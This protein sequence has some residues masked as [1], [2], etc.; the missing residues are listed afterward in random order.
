MDRCFGKP[1]FDPV[2]QWPRRHDAFFPV[3]RPQYPLSGA[4]GEEQV[5]RG[6]SAERNV[7]H[8]R[9]DQ[10]DSLS[11]FGCPPMQF[12]DFPAVGGIDIQSRRRGQDQP[13]REPCIAERLAPVTGH[14]GQ[15]H[16]GDPVA[17][18]QDGIGLAPCGIQFHLYC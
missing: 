9:Q 10:P 2:E 3:D 11:L 8:A 14:V 4:F 16:R 18:L 13:D 7:V 17:A 5:I 12:A 1:G 6:L 15:C